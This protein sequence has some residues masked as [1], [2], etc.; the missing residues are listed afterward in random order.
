MDSNAPSITTSNRKQGKKGTKV[1]KPREDLT[2]DTL[3]R[4]SSIPLPL[5]R[6]STKDQLFLAAL[7]SGI[8]GGDLLNVE[9]YTYTRRTSSGADTPRPVYA[10]EVTLKHASD[11]FVTSTSLSLSLF[12]LIIVESD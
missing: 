6:E 7:R 3:P 2:F 5:S 10:N 8:T 12:L 1:G 9:L 4:I 11:Y